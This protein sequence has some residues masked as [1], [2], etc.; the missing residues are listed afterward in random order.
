MRENHSRLCSHQC[1]KSKSSFLRPLLRRC[2][3]R[4]VL[5]RIPLC[6]FH[7][8]SGLRN[9]IGSARPSRG[10][11]GI[12]RLGRRRAVFLLCRSRGSFLRWRRHA[13]RAGFICMGFL[14]RLCSGLL[15]WNRCSFLRL[16]SLSCGT[17]CTFR[18]L[19]YI[20]FQRRDIFSCRYRI[21]ARLFA[22]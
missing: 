1:S 19:R 20:N 2:L 17:L 18:L 16:Q 14:D 7:R 8:L 15:L 4:R 21:R 6:F 3:L 11:L 13:R 5:V 9:L 10:S 12:G 22:R